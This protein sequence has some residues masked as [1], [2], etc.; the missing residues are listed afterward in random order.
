MSKQVGGFKT[1][2]KPKLKEGTCIVCG[3]EVNESNYNPSYGLRFCSWPCYEQHKS[4]NTVPNCECSICKKPMYLK[5]SRLKRTKNDVTCSFECK[6]ELKKEYMKGEKNHQFG[7]KGALNA[8]FTGDRLINEYGYIMVYLPDHPK[9][10]TNGRYREHRYIIEQSDKYPSE[11]FDIINN[12]R[13]LKDC[14]VAHH[15]N[16]IKTDNRIENIVAITISE[17]TKIHNSDKTIIRDDLGRIIGVFKSDKLLE[18][19][20]VDNQQPIITLNE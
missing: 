2:P 8:S 7:L 18:N 1:G 5:P 15:I 4:S 9:A 14:Y 6:N 16:E 17:H 3:K 19:Q 12:Q 11:Y 10:D 13:V 20:E